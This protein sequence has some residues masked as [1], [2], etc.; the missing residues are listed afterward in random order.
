MPN[1]FVPVYMFITTMVIALVTIKK[2][3]KHVGLHLTHSE[4]WVYSALV[5][6]IVMFCGYLYINRKFADQ[7][8]DHS[9][10]GVESIFSVLMVITACAM[11]FAHGSND[12]ANAIGPLSAVVSTVQNMGAL[13]TQK[14]YRLVDSSSWW[15]W[16]CGWS[17]NH[18]PQSN[19]NRWYGDYRAN[20]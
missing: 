14:C 12:V 18:G 10:A 11:A 8:E 6:A 17:C 20:A 4:A 3:L 2:G 13:T 19:G 15:Y 9:F 16:Y 7:K 5:S 1:V